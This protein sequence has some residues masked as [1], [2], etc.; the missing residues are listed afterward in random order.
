M[1]QS[2]LTRGIYP[3]WFQCLAIVE[4]G[5]PTLEQHLVNAFCLL[6][7]ISVIYIPFTSSQTDPSKHG[8]FTQ[9]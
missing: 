4:D 1:I 9:C 5:G 2:Q 6:G 7:I 3:M 8:A